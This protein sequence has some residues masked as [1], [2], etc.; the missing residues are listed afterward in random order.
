MSSQRGECTYIGTCTCR[1]YRDCP[2][3]PHN[4]SVVSRGIAAGAAVCAVTTA[5]LVPVAAP[6][7]IG[8]AAAGGGLVGGLLGRKVSGKVC[9]CGHRKDMHKKNL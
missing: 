1:Q 2:N 6:V 5:L 8:C 3:D 7:V 4:V 9:V